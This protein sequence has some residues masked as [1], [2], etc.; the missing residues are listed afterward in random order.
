MTM[1][2]IVRIQH[3][4]ALPTRLRPRNAVVNGLPLGRRSESDGNIR[5]GTGSRL[6]AGPTSN[7]A[8]SRSRVN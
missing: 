4:A 2:S 5:L 8:L 1:D 6:F 3:V 7:G